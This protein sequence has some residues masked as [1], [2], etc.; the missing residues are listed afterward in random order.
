VRLDVRQFGIDLLQRLVRAAILASRLDAGCSEA[1][2]GV[3]VR[4]KVE[5]KVWV[6][7]VVKVLVKVVVK[8]RVK[9]AVK[10]AVK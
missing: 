1:Q 8:V 10:V 7:V 5:V 3:T 2:V 4:V 9:V 6:K